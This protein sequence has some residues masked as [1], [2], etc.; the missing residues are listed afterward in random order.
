MKNV[1]ELVEKRIET[2]N[3]LIKHNAK[4]RL[5]FKANNKDLFDRLTI[6]RKE[7]LESRKEFKKSLKV[8]RRF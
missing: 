5:K 6:R 2:L 1:I 7:L 4:M 8:L 3:N